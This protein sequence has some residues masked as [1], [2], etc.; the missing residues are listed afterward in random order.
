MTPSD[1]VSTDR[2]ERVATAAMKEEPGVGRAEEML[3]A[4]IDAARAAL[5]AAPSPTPTSYEHGY[6]RGIVEAAAVL[7]GR[8]AEAILGE[9]GG[10]GGGA[11][12]APR[13]W[14]R[15]PRSP[16]RWST[17]SWS[18]TSSPRCRCEPTGSWA[19]R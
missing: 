2:R 16:G 15:P 5:V 4:L 18:C 8:N 9:P 3:D 1:A 6:C 17:T 7:R 10:G 11:R 14:S 12:G 19:W 13:R